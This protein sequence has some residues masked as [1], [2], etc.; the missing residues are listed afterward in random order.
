MIDDFKKLKNSIDQLKKIEKSI[1][2]SQKN[3]SSDGSNNQIKENGKSYA[4][5]LF[6]VTENRKRNRKKIDHSVIPKLSD[7][8][9]IDYFPTDQSKMIN[10][11]F[12]IGITRYSGFSKSSYGDPS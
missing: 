2:W 5:F 3:Q 7:Q 8:K 6:S 1:N 4:I 12:L 10:Y 11:R 9:K